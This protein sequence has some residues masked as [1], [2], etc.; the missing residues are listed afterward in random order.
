MANNMTCSFSVQTV[1]CEDDVGDAS[2]HVEALIRGRYHTTL[3]RFVSSCIVTVFNLS[4]RCKVQ[5]G[6]TILL[7]LRQ[8]D[9]N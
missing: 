5:K 6:A 7:L 3:I 1:V 8:T 2:D 9:K 4:S